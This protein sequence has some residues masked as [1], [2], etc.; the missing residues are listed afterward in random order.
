MFLHHFRHQHVVNF[1]LKNQNVTEAVIIC[2]NSLSLYYFLN[3]MLS[4]LTFK[5]NVI[6]CK[7]VF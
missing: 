4:Q 5:S 1:V 7:H 6:C 2:D 3:T